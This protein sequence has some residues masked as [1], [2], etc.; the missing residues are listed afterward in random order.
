ML[1]KEA[2]GRITEADAKTAWQALNAQMALIPAGSVPLMLCDGSFASSE[3]GSLLPRPLCRDQPAVPPISSRRSLRRPG[4][5]APEV[6]PSVVRFTD[7]TGRPVP[8]NG[9]MASSP[10][11]RPITR[12][13]ASAGTRPGLRT[14]GRQAAADRRGMAKGR[15]LARA[16]QRW[17]CNRY[18]WGDM[19][20]PTRANLSASGLGRTSRCANIAT[21][22]RRT[23]STRCRN[24]WEWLDDPLEAIPCQPG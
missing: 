21:G 18:P 22:R 23:E 14:L 10:R 20:E 1:L 17:H 9:R 15:R 2:I 7:R 11:R 6:W 12:L 4:D 5:L 13:S 16:T 3:L 19:F 8:G 24:V